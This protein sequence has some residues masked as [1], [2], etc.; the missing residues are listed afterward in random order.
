MGKSETYHWTIG[1]FHVFLHDLF[2]IISHSTV[3]GTVYGTVASSFGILYFA[4]QVSELYQSIGTQTRAP[5]GPKSTAS[6]P[7]HH[8][9]YSYGT[10]PG[11]TVHYNIYGRLVTRTS[12]V[13]DCPFSFCANIIPYITIQMQTFW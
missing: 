12:T 8:S 9:A 7:Q 4:L 13:L 5:V 11:H 6:Q 3:Y 2:R 1:Y 10:V